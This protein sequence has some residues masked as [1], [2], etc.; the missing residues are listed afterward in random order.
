M[1]VNGKSTLS[2]LGILPIPLAACASAKR[3][4]PRKVEEARNTEIRQLRR[5]ERT[6]HRTGRRDRP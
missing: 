1:N 3:A 4:E 5:V 2:G 6:R